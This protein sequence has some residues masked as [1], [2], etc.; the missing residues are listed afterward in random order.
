M[1]GVYTTPSASEIAKYEPSV[2]IVQNNNLNGYG[3]DDVKRMIDDANRGLVDD[4]KKSVV[5]K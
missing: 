5:F 2:S 4:V 1:G 3:K